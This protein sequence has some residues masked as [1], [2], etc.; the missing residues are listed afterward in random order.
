MVELLH[1]IQKPVM[2]DS[3]CINTGANYV[4]ITMVELWHLVAEIGEINNAGKIGDL[5]I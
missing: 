3:I 5:T 1:V 2:T 4:I